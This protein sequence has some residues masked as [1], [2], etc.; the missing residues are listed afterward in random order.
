MITATDT[1][2]KKGRGRPRT[3]PV[4]RI[5]SGLYESKDS[6]FRIHGTGKRGRK[7]DWKVEDITET[8]VFTE[9]QFGSFSLNQIITV[10]SAWYPESF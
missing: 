9:H 4:H 3:K 7:Q 10:L 8:E 2:N 6:R 5:Q 1:E